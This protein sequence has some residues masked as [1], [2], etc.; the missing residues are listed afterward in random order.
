MFQRILVPLDGSSASFHALE[1]A[2]EIANR[3]RTEITALYTIDARVLS[4]AR[5]YLP[6]YDEMRVSDDIVP[7]SKATLTYQAW[8]Q[9]VIAQARA[10]GESVGVKVHTDIVTG[11]P[12]QEV[13][14]RSSEFDLLVMGRW[15]AS[16]DHPGP[17]LAGSTPQFIVARTHL[18]TLCVQD[19]MREIQRILVAFDDSREALDALQLT[20]TWASAWGITLVV[21]TVQEDGDRAQSLLRK[22]HDRVR[23]TTPRLVARNG[24]PADAILATAAEHNCDLIA[25]G[26]PAGRRL[27][28][29]AGDAV[30]ETLLR[31][32]KLPV[33]LNH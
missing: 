1:Q 33:L 10:R 6:M 21:L 27:P 9:Q 30:V 3:E 8:A 18:P 23:P 11:I 13:V 31:T 19:P 17:F 29:F 28:G 14:T 22:A 20:A 12:C 4:E 7:P 5:V 25:L 24:G 15:G 32:S 16:R 2:L 26:V